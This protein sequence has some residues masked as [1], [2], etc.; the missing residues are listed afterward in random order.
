LSL[1]NSAESDGRSKQGGQ[2]PTQSDSA[3]SALLYVKFLCWLPA[4]P[5][6]GE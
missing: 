4:C 5:L 1:S 3:H 6:A 2:T